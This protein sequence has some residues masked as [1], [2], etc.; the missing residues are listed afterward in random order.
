M[1]NKN[2]ITHNT[3]QT[4]SFFKAKDDH[5]I[6]TVPMKNLVRYYN[7]CNRFYNISYH[8]NILRN[9]VIYTVLFQ[10]FSRNILQRNF[11]SI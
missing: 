4:R 11:V 6:F 2:D 1:I 10:L 9:I 3:K 7:V 5:F 8:C